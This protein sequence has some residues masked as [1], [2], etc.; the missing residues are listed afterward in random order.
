MAELGHGKVGSEGRLL[1][2]FVDDADSCR[3]SVSIA[4]A[5]GVSMKIGQHTDIGSLGHAH[6]V[7]AIADTTN[8]LFGEISDKTRD[9]CLLRRRAPTSDDSRELG[10][11][12][13]KLVLEQGKAELQGGG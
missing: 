2:L 9:V 4:F 11:D 1:A 7:P 13:N 10:R 12:V 8:A 5:H 3:G 6:V